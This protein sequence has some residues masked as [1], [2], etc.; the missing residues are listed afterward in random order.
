MSR[1]TSCSN[2][3]Y[4]SID[5]VVYFEISSFW[6]K[7]TLHVKAREFNQRHNV[8][9]AQLTRG[10]CRKIIVMKRGVPF[11]EVQAC[12]SNKPRKK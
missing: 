8:Y 7:K 12:Q 4:F 9:V 5:N 3:D 1:P 6:M 10:E 11:L 2:V